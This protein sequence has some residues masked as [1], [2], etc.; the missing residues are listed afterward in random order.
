MTVSQILAAA[1]ERY[2][3]LSEPNFS[4]VST[5]LRGGQYGHVKDSLEAAGFAV[6]EDTDENEDVCRSFV[7]GRSGQTRVLQL[8]LVI[9]AMVVLSPEGI[10]EDGTKPVVAEVL[11]LLEEAGCSP[12]TVVGRDLAGVKVRFGDEMVPL[13][14]VLFSDTEGMPA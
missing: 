12:M 8:S 1:S 9:P 3:S 2:G 14:R 11:S 10:V 6:R 13:Y 5:A 4:F 7:L